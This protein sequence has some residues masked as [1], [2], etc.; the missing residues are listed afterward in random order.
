MISPHYLYIIG[1]IL[2]S[3]YLL[4]GWDDLIWDLVT[5]LSVRNTANKL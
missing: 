1:F 4:M 3:L 2:V 5:L